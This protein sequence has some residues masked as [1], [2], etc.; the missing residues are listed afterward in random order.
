MIRL[1]KDAPNDCRKG[2]G[3]MTPGDELD[4]SVNGCEN[5]RSVKAVSVSCYHVEELKMRY[6]VVRDE[7]LNVTIR[8]PFGRPQSKTPIWFIDDWQPRTTNG[9]EQIGRGCREELGEWDDFIECNAGGI[10]TE[11]IVNA[12][13]RWQLVITWIVDADSEEDA[14]AWI[15]MKGSDLRIS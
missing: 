12:R 4:G 11:G 1:S 15:P 9:A 10:V 5:G 2:G 14:L 7:M 8:Y 13:Q 3:A 6:Q